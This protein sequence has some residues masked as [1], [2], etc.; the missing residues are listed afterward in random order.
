MLLSCWLLLAAVAMSGCRLV[1]PAAYTLFLD[2]FMAVAPSS[3]DETAVWKPPL[4]QRAT[5]KV[6]KN[7]VCSVFIPANRPAGQ[8]TAR[9]VQWRLGFFEVSVFG[10]S[11]FS[12]IIVR[13]AIVASQVS[14]Y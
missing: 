12:Q 14:L 4:Q 11:D 9:C 3:G 10:N 7:F 1:E 6:Q 2:I 5:L 13:R 8:N